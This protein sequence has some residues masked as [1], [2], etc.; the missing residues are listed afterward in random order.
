MQISDPR[1]ISTLEVIH[2]LLFRAKVNYYQQAWAK[3]NNSNVINK[4]SRAGTL[5]QYHWPHMDAWK[6]AHGGP[7]E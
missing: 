3:N 2:F 7:V 5:L 1:H 4:F 6:V